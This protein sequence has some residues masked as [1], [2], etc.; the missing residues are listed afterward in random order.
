MQGLCRVEA[1]ST[2][3]Q[4]ICEICQQIDFEELLKMDVRA[5]E[6]IDDE[7]KGLVVAELQ[8]YEK[9]I[10]NGCVLCGLFC[11]VM[12]HL[13]RGKQK[14]QL[15]ARS[16]FG[17]YSSTVRYREEISEMD[18][19]ALEVLPSQ[20]S[21]EKSGF[22]RLYR[23]GALLLHQ[24]SIKYPWLFRPRKVA[25]FID[26]GVVTQW[27]NY[28]TTH[29]QKLCGN[30]GMPPHGLKLID[31]F[32]MTITHAKPS[33]EYVALS[34]VLGPSKDDNNFI[35][36]SGASI[37]L[38][39][40]R[41]PAVISDAIL[42][43]K[44][45][46]MRYLWV[47]KLC[48]DQSNELEKYHQIS[49]MDEVYKKAELCIIATAGDETTGL[50]GVGILPREWQPATTL[51]NIDIIFT[52][53]HPHHSIETSKWS[54][55]GW[56]YQE[57]VLSRHRLVFT[58]NQ[59]YFECNAMHCCES[60]QRNLDLIHGKEKHQYRDFMAPGIFSGIQ[61]YDDLHINANV[62][63]EAW[64][65]Y[66]NHVEIFSSRKLSCEEDS[67]R[68]FQGI[69]KS[70]AKFEFPVHQLWGVP[71]LA[72]KENQATYDSLARGL[73]WWHHGADTHGCKYPCR[74]N[75]F[76]SWS[77]A[78]WSGGMELPIS[79]P[80]FDV[81]SYIGP[82]Y[83]EFDSGTLVE[84]CYLSR[85]TPANDL[86]LS[87]PRALHMDAIVIPKEAIL[88]EGQSITVGGWKFRFRSS[89]PADEIGWGQSFATRRYQMVLLGSVFHYDI[90]DLR[91]YVMVIMHDEGSASRVG[92]GRIDIS[93]QELSARV[94]LGRRRIRLV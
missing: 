70:L 53:K 66:T 91:T 48:I 12:S 50:P 35:S 39:H 57:A 3:Y 87:Y 17:T 49:Q 23:H 52:M 73:T 28:C 1:M 14:Y 13:D 33:D 79:A 60:L 47:D 93:L 68:A 54:T 65:R 6:K 37:H 5:L 10:G 51:N 88:V 81:K 80:A 20:D 64:R 15:V 40:E 77:W 11:S 34:Y 62:E 90:S 46:H 16:F 4:Y 86:S 41:L 32:S 58:E 56:T 19:P 30:E 8:S 72:R 63:F 67:L 74:R 83:L 59:L 25:P 71:F 75:D 94:L 7:D 24:T 27:L 89:V 29:H 26:Y 76:P 2:P 22:G 36:R 61:P 44:S 31:C 84:L 45:L 43:T 92:A 38:L 55:R 82:V 85:N 18:Q 21:S 78:G 42:V 9:M 69:I